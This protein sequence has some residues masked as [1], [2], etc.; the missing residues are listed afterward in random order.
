MLALPKHF[1]SQFR[2]CLQFA[3]FPQGCRA[4]SIADPNYVRRNVVIIGKDNAGRK[5]CLT[6][7]GFQTPGIQESRETNT[8]ELVM[9]VWL[10]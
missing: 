10:L 3:I 9:P 6:E 4:P 8:S 5:I 2:G 1:D 7:A